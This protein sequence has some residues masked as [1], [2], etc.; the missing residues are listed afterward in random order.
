MNSQ[1][2]TEDQIVYVDR[3][4]DV[5]CANH[6]LREAPITNAANTGYVTVISEDD[7]FHI[8]WV[9]DGEVHVDAC[10]LRKREWAV[11]HGQRTAKKMLTEFSANRGVGD[12]EETSR[13][14]FRML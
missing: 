13:T 2:F 11:E 8:A 5:T 10:A 7:G 3:P 14:A 1:E 9:N 6:R 4:E 12:A